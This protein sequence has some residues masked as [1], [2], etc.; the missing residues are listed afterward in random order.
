MLGTFVVGVVPPLSSMFFLFTSLILFYGVSSAKTDLHNQCM[1]SLCVYFIFFEI[2]EKRWPKFA[3]I[4]N[5]D[6][7]SP[8]FDRKHFKRKKVWEYGVNFWKNGRF[9]SRTQ[10]RTLRSETIFDKWKPFKNDEKCFLFHLKSPFS[11]QDIW[12]FVLTVW[13]CGKTTWLE[14]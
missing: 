4:S 11:S 10:K 7:C 2:Y 13:S 3:R 1:I 9:V 14:R 12:I 5:R 8:K 6:W